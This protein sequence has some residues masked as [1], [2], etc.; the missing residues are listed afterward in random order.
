[1]KT[2]SVQKQN[3]LMFLKRNENWNVNADAFLSDKFSLWPI[4]F[5]FNIWNVKHLQKRISLFNQ[6]SRYMSFNYLCRILHIGCMSGRRWC[7]SYVKGFFQEVASFFITKGIRKWTRWRSR[8]NSIS[9]TQERIWR[10]LFCHTFN[11]PPD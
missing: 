8:W 5:T 4:Y 11:Q 1:M 9:K 6:Q 2:N 10:R 7:T 3:L